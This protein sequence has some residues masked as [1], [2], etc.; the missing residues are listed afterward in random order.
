MHPDAPL[1]IAF[2]TYRGNPHSGGQ[3]VYARH[4]TRALADLGH[5]VEVLSGQPYPDLDARV[6]LVPL[7]SFDLYNADHPLRL[8]AP[9]RIRSVGDWVELATFATL[10]FPEPLAFSVRAAVHL[11]RRRADFD[12]VHDNQSLGWG[13]LAIE[14]AGLPVLA[15]VHHPITVDLRLELARAESWHRRWLWRRWYAFTRMQ[16]RVAPRLRRIVTDSASSLD[17]IRSD[18]GVPAA[19]LHVVPVGVDPAIFRPRDDVATV[20]GR[21]VTTASADS[22]MKGLPY[23]LEALA[24]LRRRRAVHLVVV[25]TLRADGPT[26]RTIRDLALEDAV[27]FVSGVSEERLVALYNEAAVVVV[28]SVYEGFSLPAVE[29][30]ACGRAVVAT[31]G[32]ALPEV[33]GADGETALLVPPANA[34]ALAAAIDRVLDDAPLRARLGAAGRARVAARWTWRHT[35]E[36]TAAHY[37]A[38][39][40]EAQV[41]RRSVVPA[42]AC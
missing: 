9:S 20:P 3:G 17:D 36:R 2:L 6:P 7:P 18:L 16:R 12:V 13:L 21:I 15:T 4:L 25:G 32:G 19:R 28:P 35:A 26:A 1:R 24:I 22:A 34:G 40:A 39:I 33:L 38:V 29:A 41:S 5:R 42:A 37:R 11:R 23:L 31:T 14:R 30:Q 10:A 27:T 8:P